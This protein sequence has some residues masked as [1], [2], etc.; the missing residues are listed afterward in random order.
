MVNG[1]VKAY[2]NRG[3]S[4]TYIFLSVWAIIFLGI[5]AILF[6]TEKYGNI[7]VTPSDSEELDKYYKICLY[8]CI[9]YVVLLFLCVINFVWRTTHPFP[10]GTDNATASQRLQRP[11]DFGIETMPTDQI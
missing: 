8:A 2:T 7:G 4:A 11:S 6:K 10:K 1:F 5:L 3:C 9:A